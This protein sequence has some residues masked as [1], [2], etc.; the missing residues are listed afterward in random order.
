[1]NPGATSKDAILQVCRR[2][3]AQEGLSA[4][5]MRAVARECGVALGT[6]YNYYADKDALLIAAVESIWR[7]IFHMDGND[8]AG[9]GHEPVLRR[10]RVHLRHGG[11]RSHPDR[12]GADSAAGVA[13]ACGKEL[14][15]AKAAAQRHKKK[16]ET[17][18]TG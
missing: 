10:F 5:S 8:W 7:E 3:A 9:A 2:M 18:R 11:H 1:M 4:L 13:Q 6:L 17:V 15:G 12:R 16:E 14:S